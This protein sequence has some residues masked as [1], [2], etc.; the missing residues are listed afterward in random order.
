MHDLFSTTA[1]ACARRWKQLRDEFVKNRRKKP[2][3]DVGGVAAKPWKYDTEMSFL[4][5]HLTPRP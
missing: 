4:V 2:S 1:D 3:G 5:P